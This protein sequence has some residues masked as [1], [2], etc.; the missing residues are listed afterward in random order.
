MYI[1]NSTQFSA[2]I[3]Q[4]LMNSVGYKQNFL[5]RLRYK[6]KKLPHVYGYSRAYFMGEKISIS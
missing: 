5:L 6:Q 3:K 4:L 1:N 2:L